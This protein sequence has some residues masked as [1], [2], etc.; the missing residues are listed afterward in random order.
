MAKV[1]I[2]IFSLSIISCGKKNLK[3][4]GLLK[5]SMKRPNPESVL[6]TLGSVICGYRYEKATEST[7][8][9]QLKQ[10][11]G[12][13]ISTNSRFDKRRLDDGTTVYTKNGINIDSEISFRP[14]KFLFSDPEGEFLLAIDSTDDHEIKMS[15]KKYNGYFIL[16]TFHDLRHKQEKCNTFALRLLSEGHFLEVI[17]PQNA[18]VS[19]TVYPINEFFKSNPTS[20]SFKIFEHKNLN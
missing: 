4:D 18:D 20:E 2:L 9:K 11:K 19:S 8:W 13:W 17:G 16:Q 5:N 7:Q 6:Q 12:L 15:Q 3:N 10:F 1:I 14:V